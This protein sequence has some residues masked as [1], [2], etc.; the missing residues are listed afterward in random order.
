MTFFLL[1]LAGLPPT[2]GFTGK[3]LILAS[4]VNAGY[5]WLAGMLVLGTAISIYAYA[6]VIYAMYARRTGVTDQPPAKPSAPLP[7]IAV[8]ICAAAVLVL[9][10]YPLA[11]SDVLPTLK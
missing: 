8:T 10:F 9:T 3:L 7:W 4:S 1:A 2:A 5:A 6:K 11:P